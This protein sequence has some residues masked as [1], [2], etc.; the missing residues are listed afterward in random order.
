[1]SD[2]PQLTFNIFH[3]PEVV[4]RIGELL[5]APTLRKK[6]LLRRLALW[7]ERITR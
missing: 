5:F 4:K 2:R 1:M 6:S 7:F 3:D